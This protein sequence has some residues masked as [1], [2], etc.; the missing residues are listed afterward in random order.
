M[1]ITSIVSHLI[2]SVARVSVVRDLRVLAAPIPVAVPSRL[3]GISAV[4]RFLQLVWQEP[5][6]VER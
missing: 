6:E 4:V 2:A 5:G 1:L 3:K